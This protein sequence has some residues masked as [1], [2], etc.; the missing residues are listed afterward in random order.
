MSAQYDQ[1]G[2][3]VADWD[4]LPVRSEY[5]E[6]HTF[7]KALGSVEERNVLDLACGDGLYTRQ[8]K[9]RGANRVV[10]VDISE[11]MI[12]GARR[13]EEAQRLGI[14]Y[15]V[16]DVADMAPLGVFD[17][18]TAVYLLHY[19][20]SP[21][22]LLRMCRNIHAHVKPG[23]RFV[24]YSFNP[25]FSAKGPN[26]T[27][28]GIT[29]LDFPESPREGQAISAELHTKTPFTIHFSYWSRATYEQ[30]LR[31]AGFRQ[32]TWMSPEC[33]P[34]GIARYGRAFWQDYLDNP[35]AVALR[36]E[37]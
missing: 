6:G 31:E 23:G 30:A 27:R 12:G 17:C 11:E 34:E 16:S 35:H 18:V 5:I 7:F 3:K 19:A 26:S 14:E 10:G 4:V 22:H 15:H 8:L 32:L 37:R 25:G 13:Y 9:A 21:E 20:N 1:I 24:T 29:M 28:Y 36:C 33:S 2:E